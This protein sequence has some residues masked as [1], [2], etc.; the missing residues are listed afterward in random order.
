M[1]NAGVVHEQSHRLGSADLG[2][3]ADTLRRGEVGDDGADRGFGVRNGELFQAFLASAY[4]HQIVT[5]GSQAFGECPADSG[6][7]AC[8]KC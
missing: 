5:V 2:D 1:G 8:D 6:A 3:R 7:G 4:D